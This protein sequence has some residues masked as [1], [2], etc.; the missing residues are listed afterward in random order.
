MKWLN[1][2]IIFL[3]AL[4]SVSCARI[5]GNGEIVSATR[6]AL[7]FDEIEL[8]DAFN[9]YVYKTDYYKIEIECESNLLN[10]IITT[11]EDGKLIIKTRAGVW[12]NTNEPV[13]IYVYTP[14]C[15][16]AEV[17]GSGN[18]YI[19]ELLDDDLDL[20]ITGS[21]KIVL[22]DS[23]FTCDDL[24]VTIAGSGAVIIPDVHF[25]KEVD[26]DIMGSGYT[27]MA[28]HSNELEIDISGSGSVNLFGVANYADLK[29][30]G[31]GL[32]DA[33]D[34]DIQKCDVK[35]NGSGNAY[36]YVLDILNIHGNGSGCVYYKGTPA[37]NLSGNGNLINRN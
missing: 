26:I 18:I 9:V 17:S 14:F 36:L 8:W 15:N 35:I 20:S 22:L 16:E 28:L 5:N 31:S 34:M 33:Y 10:H 11:F 3:L 13:N 12:F 21:G 25:I 32:V 7:M 30:N 2:S 4:C 19:E 1:S 6:A 37:I 24:S 23:T 29:I 27:D